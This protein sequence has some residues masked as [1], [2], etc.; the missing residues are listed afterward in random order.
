MALTLTKIKRLP[1]TVRRWYR[2]RFR[3][4]FVVLVRWHD[5]VTRV[6]W[7]YASS[8]EDALE[9]AAQYPPEDSVTIFNCQFGVP[10]SVAGER[11]L[12]SYSGRVYC[13]S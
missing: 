5:D 12:Y 3:S 9:W 13:Y 1:R 2:E 4:P 8:Y 7:H 10:L 6:S 11:S